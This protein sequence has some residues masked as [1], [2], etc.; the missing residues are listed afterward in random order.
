MPGIEQVIKEVNKKFKA[1]LVTEGIRYESLPRIPFS[2]PRLNYMTYGGIPT[3]RI[4]EFSGDEGSGKTTSALDIVKNA[5]HIYPDRKV[6]YVDCENTLDEAWATNLG[7]NV[8]DLI[9]FQPSTE[10]AEEIFSVIA[11]LV[12]TG[13]ISL[14]VIDSLGVMISAQAYDK[15]MEGKTYGGISAALTLF[16]K[17][18][19][20]LLIKYDCTLIGINQMRDDMNSQYGGSTTTGGRSWKHNCSMRIEFRQSDYIDEKGNSIS[21]GVEN[22]AGNLVKCYLKKSK[23]CRCDR[24]ISFYTLNY[25][26]GIDYITDTIDVAVKENIISCSGA[27]YSL[28]NPDTG[29]LLT[30]GDRKLQFQGKL[31]LKQFLSENTDILED[32]M[33]RVHEINVK[34]R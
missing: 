21:R 32:I 24:K 23:V 27:W 22:P 29:E 9:V 5:Q 10:T 4:V 11:D 30:I 15:G 17:M 2:S 20:P 13:D 7:V 31:K 19:V 25:L 14:A 18:M 3:R 28:V 1:S 16:S 12:S 6:L 33:Q 26:E 8:N 34:N